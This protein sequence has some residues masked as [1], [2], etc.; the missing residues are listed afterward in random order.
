MQEAWEIWGILTE[1]LVPE[2]FSKVNTQTYMVVLNKM[3]FLEQG[4][5][6]MNGFI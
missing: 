2:I 5:K 3:K 1:F 6:Y 4:C